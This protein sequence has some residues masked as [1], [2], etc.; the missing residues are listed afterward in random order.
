MRAL[1]TSLPTTSSSRRQTSQP[2][3]QLLQAF[4]SAALSVTN[5]YKTAASE[6]SQARAAGFQ[7]A[8][9]ELLAFLDKENLGLGDGEGWRVRQWATERLDSGVP[10][11]PNSDTDE[12]VEEHKPAGSNSPVVARKNSP[13]E[14]K[15]TEAL[16]SESSAH[17]EPASL[18]SGT[19][20]ASSPNRQTRASPCRAESFTFRSS[21]PYPQT[22]DV[23]MDA[24]NNNGN[25]TPALRVEV[26]PRNSR[27]S[28]RH[29]PNGR[30]THRAPPSV[31]SLG[32]G[33][34]QKRKVPF[35]DFFDIS[36]FF[37][38][39]DGASGGGKRGRHA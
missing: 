20:R 8:L 3:E 5:L 21:L 22:H 34:G 35:P 19:V 25:S 39:K 38:D 33:A 31:T 6:Q 13:E 4:K 15:Q 17:T 26:L 30:S 7:D 2:P 27:T 10:G 28:P 18:G 14:L 32:A 11:Q 16:R 24:T 9:D 36:G 1:N 12:E 23:D 29:R 37:N